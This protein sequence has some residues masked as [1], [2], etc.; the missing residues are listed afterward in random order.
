VVVVA[1]AATLLPPV[2]VSATGARQTRRTSALLP[3]HRPAPR[4]L[5][6][7]ACAQ[8]KRHTNRRCRQRQMKIGDSGTGLGL[9]SRR[10]D[11]ARAVPERTGVDQ[12]LTSSGVLTRYGPGSN[13]LVAGSN[14]TWR[15]LP[16]A[17][18]GTR[19]DAGSG[20]CPGS[21]LDARALKP[22]FR[23][24]DVTPVSLSA[25]Q[26]EAERSALVSGLAWHIATSIAAL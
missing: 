21:F 26:P 15:V 18:R 2:A 16:G 4:R 11:N 1:L 20:V 22:T 13:P 25:I 14:P 9:N 23:H 8:A 12:R 6:R 7:S 24:A 17:R 10:T 19:A 3:T 5:L